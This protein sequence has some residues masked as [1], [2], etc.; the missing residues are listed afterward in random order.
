[1][2]AATERIVVQPTLTQKKA[3]CWDIWSEGKAVTRRDIAAR[4]P[5]E[6]LSPVAHLLDVLKEVQAHLQNSGPIEEIM[7]SD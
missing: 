2:P 4:V 7:S 6:I 1:M 3:V 5:A